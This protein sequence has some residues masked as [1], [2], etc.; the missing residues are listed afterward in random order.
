[1]KCAVKLTNLLLKLR[2]SFLQSLF[3]G[4][5]LYWV[6][7]HFLFNE[8][9]N[10]FVARVHVIS[11]MHFVLE[12]VTSQGVRVGQ[13]IFSSG[14]IV[15]ETP[16][17]LLYTRSGSAPHLIHEVLQD[18]PERPLAALM[19]L[20][21]LYAFRLPASLLCTCVCPLLAMNFRER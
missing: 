7:H 3:F 6:H 16:M 17:C 9:F 14:R 11:E 5:E 8:H 19:T 1:M 15:Q 12:K 4:S 13:L 21:T 18:I 10:V 2:I 20:P